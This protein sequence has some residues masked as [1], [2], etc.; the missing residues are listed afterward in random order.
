MPRING[1]NSSNEGGNNG[2]SRSV[3]KAMKGI[4]LAK[5]LPHKNKAVDATLSQRPGL[6]GGAA[7]STTITSTGS[8][9]YTVP[10]GVDTITVEMV[11]GGGGGGAR[12]GKGGGANGG[13]GGSGAKV[14]VTLSEI[15]PGTVLTFNVGAAGAQ[16]THASQVS[17]RATAG[18]DTTLTH[19]G[20]TYTAGG[21]AGGAGGGD[22]SNTAGVDESGGAGS[23]TGA[24]ITAGNAGTG[25]G[26]SNAGTG[27]STTASTGTFGAGGQ[28]QT[29]ST[30]KTDGTAGFVK[31]T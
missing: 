31:I 12:A 30:G 8:Q 2:K 27:G 23:G 19:G 9:T 21:G 6:F 4:R 25:Q 16:G 29:A 14:V 13:G 24:T 7:S 18:G 5:R 17:G 26:G 22:N 3:A 28:G 20:V 11:G 10:K 15:R 1:N